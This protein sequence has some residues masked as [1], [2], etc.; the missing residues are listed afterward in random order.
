MFRSCAAGISTAPR[1]MRCSSARRRAA[2]AAIS[3][4]RPIP[5]SSGMTSY[6]PI[7]PVAADPPATDLTAGD[8]DCAQMVRGAAAAAR[9]TS[10][11]EVRSEEHTS[12]LQSHHDLVCRLLLEKKKKT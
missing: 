9:A 4:G 8:A 7:G 10:A 2:V 3:T 5:G 1:P 12:E 6:A 11:I